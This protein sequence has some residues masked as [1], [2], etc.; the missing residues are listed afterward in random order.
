MPP[1]MKPATATLSTN[2]LTVPGNFPV[3]EYE[4]VQRT[5]SSKYGAHALY[6]H[7]GGAWNALAY[8]YRECCDSGER[9]LLL[10]QRYGG[11]P[12]PEERYRQERAL[13]DFFSAGF[14]IFEC[15]FYALYT[16][17]AIGSPAHFS[18]ATERE[19]QQV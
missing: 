2:G 1:S 9:F 13:F 4:S 6:A 12:P 7:Y 5:L 17:G 3:T 19:Q 11:S 10:L 18:L 16:F 14:S 15:T 8:R